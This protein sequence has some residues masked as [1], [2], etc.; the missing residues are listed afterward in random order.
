[1]FAVGAVAFLDRVNISIAGS[2]IA[3][4]F[5]LSD[6]QLGYIFSAL[7]VGYAIF[8]TLGGGTADRFGHP[9]WWPWPLSGVVYSPRSLSR[10]TGN[11]SS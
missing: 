10:C 11:G 4:E 9:G 8:Q 5:H 3:V 6:V 2:P 1:M 7:R